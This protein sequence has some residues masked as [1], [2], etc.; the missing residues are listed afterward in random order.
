MIR[1]KIYADNAA[2][3]KLDP[4]AFDDMTPFF[5]DEYANASQPYAFAYRPKKALK[6]ARR[7]IAE[8]IGAYPDEIFFT[9]GGSESD[10]WVIRSAPL[11]SPQK[12]TLV[13]SAFEH[14]AVLHACQAAQNG[15]LRVVTL[16]PSPQGFILPQTLKNELS[17]KVGLVSI[18]F[19]NNELGTVQ[20]IAQLCEQAHQCGAY[21]HTDAV[22]AVGHL[23]IDVHQLG[24]D[25]LSAS[26]HK[27][28]GPKGIGFLYVRRGIPL[29][30]YVHGG[31]QENH[32]RAGTENIPAIVG[33]ATALRN[34]CSHLDANQH[35]LQ[36]LESLLLSLLD[37]AAIPYQRNGSAP[38]LPGLLS[39]S[40]PNQDGEALLHRLDLMGIAV[41]TGAACDSRQ[42]QIS[43]VLQAI[44]LAPSAALGTI[45]ISLGKYNTTSD[46]EAIA[47]ALV[48]VLRGSHQ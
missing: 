31:A 20:P 13:T 42:T 8:S 23:P 18:M 35:H 38:F 3:T 21:F 2:T 7:S 27:F 22:Q 40:F 28:N 11:L 17:E 6:D 36:S 9:S 25:F 48:K 10:N 16:S 24:V 5:L 12:N 19:A 34:H 46:V 15:G 41:S 32:K 14:H 45:R 47:H 44:Q 4:E 37:R 43:H 26:A 39:L 30:P 29:L 33:M 1:M